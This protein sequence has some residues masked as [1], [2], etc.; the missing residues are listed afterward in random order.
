MD[1]RQQNIYDNLL[2][3]VV[4]NLEQFPKKSGQEGT[5]YFINDDLV[6]KEM[7][8]SQDSIFKYE[9]F[10]QYCRELQDF[11]AQGYA[12][13]EIYSW[14]MLPKTLFKNSIFD[15]YYVLQERVKGR[16][17]FSKSLC[18][19]YEDCSSFC[20]KQEFEAAILSKKGELFKRIVETYLKN[21]L[22][23]IEKLDNM[24]ECL[25]ENFV[26]SDYGMMKN[27]TYGAVDVHGA[28]VLFDG[29]KLV[30]IDN[31]FMENFFAGYSDEKIRQITMKDILRIM[32]GNLDVLACYG[33]YKKRWP[34]LTTLYSKHKTACKSVMKKFINVTNRT[35]KPVFSEDMEFFN[36]R[37]FISQVMCGE[38]EAEL[39]G[40][41]QKNF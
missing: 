21:S 17:M 15:R 8:G 26:L 25:I 39:V 34:E 35:L 33:Y 38:D 4:F 20:T 30:I 18:N 5:A 6:V 40:M 32:S 3:S 24:P 11:H 9:N 22:E 41:L 12:V 36:S 27:H 19:T 7:M 13:P 28:N 14:T 16:D 2:L 29:E 1:K 23:L 31:G 37:D 10:E